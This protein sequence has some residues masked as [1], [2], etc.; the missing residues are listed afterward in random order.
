MGTISKFN[1]SREEP[2]AKVCAKCKH[3]RPFK[4]EKGNVTGE[5]ECR[6]HPPQLVPIRSQAVGEMQ[7]GESPSIISK[8]TGGKIGKPVPVM[9]TNSQHLSAWSFC[10]TTADADCGEFKEKGMVS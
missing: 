10:N 8:V 7:A 6:A 1:Q 9:V 5:G 3:Y 4:N 2:I